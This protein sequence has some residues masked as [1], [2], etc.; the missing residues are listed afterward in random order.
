MDTTLLKCADSPADDLPIART[1]VCEVDGWTGR[2]DVV[3]VNQPEKWNRGLRMIV[4]ALLIPWLEEE[5]RKSTK[6]RTP[7]EIPTHKCK[8]I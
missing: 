1:V 6:G 4:N 5:G 8:N 3:Y 7:S 2:M